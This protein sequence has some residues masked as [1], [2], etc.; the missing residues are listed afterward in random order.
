[1]R[2]TAAKG[3]RYGH[4]KVSLD[5]QIAAEGDFH[6]KDEDEQDLSLGTR[7]LSKGPH[8]LSFTAVG[9][10]AEEGGQPTAKP[11]AVEMLRLLELPPMAVR[12][13]K[14][15]NEVHFVRLGIGRSLYAYRMAYGKLPDT[16]E[17]LVTS[18]IMP[19]R[20]MNNKNGLPLKCWREGEYFAVQSPAA[21]GW[22]AR[23][24]GLDVRR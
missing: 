7:V 5:G 17:T 15:E 13:V 16:L 4:C 22:K 6:A 11:I 3:P 8:T 21:N 9:S 18:G 19:K 24:Q 14:N 10:P 23:W 1:M 20:Y 12:K 2:L